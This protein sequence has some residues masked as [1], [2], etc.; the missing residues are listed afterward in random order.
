[1]VLP[2]GS[3]SGTR[4]AV[5][6]WHVTEPETE[7]KMLLQRLGY[8][9]KEAQ[10]GRQSRASGV[11][12]VTPNSRQ[13][14]GLR[15][16][17]RNLGEREDVVRGAG[18]TVR[19]PLCGE[20]QRAAPGRVTQTESVR[21]DAR[22]QGAHRAMAALYGCYGFA[23]ATSQGWSVGRAKPRVGIPLHSKKTG[24]VAEYR[25]DPR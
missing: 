8:P 25:L 23:S 14:R 3:A 1:M 9:F 2:A 17:V 16:Q 13:S 4:T 11:K 10:T 21:H 6:L 18:L 7:Q 20:L 15:F 5:R 19:E 24:G 12:T 22:G